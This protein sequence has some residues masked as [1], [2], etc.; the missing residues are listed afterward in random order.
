MV[1]KEI[2]AS[3]RQ[4]NI[5]FAIGKLN[6]YE[7]FKEQFIHAVVAMGEIGNARKVISMWL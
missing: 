3:C 4:Y 5:L 7:K 2:V 6:E 1:A